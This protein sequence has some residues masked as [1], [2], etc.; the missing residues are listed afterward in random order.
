[1]PL[2]L[3]GED[4]EAKICSIPGWWI[5]FD[6]SFRISN[7]NDRDESYSVDFEAPAAIP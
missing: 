3:G 6:Q 2:I 4:S 5:E 7:R 1:M